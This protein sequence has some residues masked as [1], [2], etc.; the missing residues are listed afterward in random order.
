MSTSRL[1]SIIAT[2]RA[3]LLRA[4]Q[5]AVQMLEHAYQHTLS[6]LQP[7][8]DTLF[9]DMEALVAAGEDIPL[10]WL[11]EHHRLAMLTAHIQQE[12]TRYGDTTQLVVS[13]QQHQSVNLGTQAALEQLKSTVPPGVHW[14]FGLPSPQAIAALIGAT[15]AG[16][17]LADLFRGFGAEA[18]QKASQS[19]ISGVTLGNNP[20]VIARAVQQDLGISRARALTICRTEQLRAYRSA[21]LLT[22][23]QNDDVVAGWYWQSALDTRCCSACIAMHGT[24]HKLDEEMGSH[25]NCRCT[26]VPKTKDW[27]DILS[28]LG[29]DTEGLVDTSYQPVRGADWLDQQSEA[30]QRDVLGNKYDGWNNGDFSLEDIVGYDDDEDWG[31]AI[32]EKSL[33]QLMKRR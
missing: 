9:Q 31:R 1:H 8:L 11:Y 17:P 15:K 4:E 30:V 25:P 14:S 5:Q 33:K 24:F 12:M 2:Y 27:S 26:M 6:T 22:L 23:Q 32:Y 21:Q 20:R 10:S 29:I 7:L 18:A 16:S 28:P 13:Q 3:D 19:L